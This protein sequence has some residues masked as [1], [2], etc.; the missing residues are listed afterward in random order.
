MFS[1]LHTLI[2]REIIEGLRFDENKKY[3]S[4]YE[5]VLKVINKTNV[6]KSVENSLYAKRQRD[7]IIKSP[8]LYE[9]ADADYFKYSIEEY[10]NTKYLIEEINNQETKD[11]LKEVL[12]T[13]FIEFYFNDFSKNYRS[14]K[15]WRKDNF[16]KMCDIAKDLKFKTNKKELLALQQHDKKTVEKSIN[17]R[18]AKEKLKEIITGFDKNLLLSTIYI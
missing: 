17:R 5:F 3:F 12:N 4:D 10:E 7:D 11:T 8:S 16:E 15:K 14:K 9:E 1:V 6:F 13:K 18:L 2:K